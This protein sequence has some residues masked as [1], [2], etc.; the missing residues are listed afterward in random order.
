[1][2]VSFE[3]DDDVRKGKNRG[4]GRAILRWE[5]PIAN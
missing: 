5:R 1:M 3:I 4:G 2:V